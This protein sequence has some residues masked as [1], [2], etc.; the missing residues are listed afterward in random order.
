MRSKKAITVAEAIAGP[1]ARL[2]R[3]R[4]CPTCGCDLF[5]KVDLG[6]GRLVFR[7]AGTWSN[8]D[9]CNR[10]RPIPILKGPPPV[11][12]LL[13]GGAAEV[14]IAAS[15]PRGDGTGS[16]APAE[17]RAAMIRSAEAI[18]RRPEVKRARDVEESARALKAITDARRAGMPGDRPEPLPVE[19]YEEFFRS[20]R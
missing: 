4:P 15:S 1:E 5:E 7:C 11:A 13:E 14:A 6:D 16:A 12:T 8:G 19:A 18:A 10:L 3:D 20:R 17:A 2:V 9:D